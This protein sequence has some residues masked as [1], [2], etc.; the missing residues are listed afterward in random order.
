MTRQWIACVVLA[1]AAV[2]AA[3]MELAGVT[4][5]DEVT[6]GGATLNLNG[7]ELRTKTMLK[8]KV[9]VAGLYLATASHDAAAIIA[10]DEPKQVVMHFLYKKV[11]KDKLTKAWR[12]GFA[13]NFAAALPSLKAR[14]DEFCALW[15]DMA[16][17]ERAVITYLPD[18]GTRLE[19]NGKEA[20]V[21]PGKDFADAMFAVWLGA[22]PADAGLKEGMLGK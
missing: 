6:V 11:E 21:I 14:L 18:T 7:M 9:Y 15:P 13:N 22:K 2:P 17:G 8:V 10:A 4:L 12:E 19:L 3:A 5:P 16:S 1:L 20:G